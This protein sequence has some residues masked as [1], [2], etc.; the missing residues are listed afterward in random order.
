MPT[1]TWQNILS[2]AHQVLQELA[3]T[4]RTTL[5]RPE[6]LTLAER[7]EHVRIDEA[8]RTN[9]LDERPRVIHWDDPDCFDDLHGEEEAPA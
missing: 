2:Q 1:E 5:T 8:Q 9:S 7:V 6:L 4:G 3:D